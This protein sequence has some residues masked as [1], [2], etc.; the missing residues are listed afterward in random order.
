MPHHESIVIAAYGPLDFGVWLGIL[1]GW[2]AAELE[3]STCWWRNFSYF[4]FHSVLI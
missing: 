4:T 3:V 2:N 1:A